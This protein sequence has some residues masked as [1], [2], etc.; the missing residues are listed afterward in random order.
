MA[1][2]G[3]Y[4][5]LS[6]DDAVHRSKEVLKVFGKRGVECIRIGLCSSD[7]LGD[8]SKVMGGANHP[9]LGELVEGELYFDR[10]CELAERLQGDLH[11]KTA[12]VIVPRGHT[13]RAVGQRGVNRSRLIAKYGLSRIV[14][15]EKNVSEISLA[16]E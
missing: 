15:E 3:E 14:I 10:M 12:L 4:E 5:M 2:R 13:S 8:D 16:L 6:L 1:E 9:A 11:G 7:N